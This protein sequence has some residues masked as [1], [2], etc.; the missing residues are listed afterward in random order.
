MKNRLTDRFDDA[1]VYASRLH[2]EQPRKGTETP[3]LAHLMG[4][5]SL[6]LENGA[7][8]DQA[9]AALLH[10]AVEDQG[11]LPTLAAIRARFGD[12]VAQIVADC[13]DTKDPKPARHDGLPSAQDRKE[14][15]ER[16]E[17]YIVGLVAKPPASLLVSLADKTHN[18]MAIVADLDAHG[19]QVWDRFTGGKA[20]TLWYYT[21]LATAFS[22]LLPG[23][24]STRFA[25]IAGDLNVRHG[26]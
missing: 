11:G 9:I 14:W 13:T 8:E 15:Q 1:F 10:D 23:A 24:A 25:G 12:R 20:G 6:A 4:V 7:D 19:E 2:R 16:K 5:A 3:Y 22:T 17:A 18:A 26:G 21:A